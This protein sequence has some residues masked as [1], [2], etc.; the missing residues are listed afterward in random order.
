MILFAF[1]ALL[2]AA[3]WLI[4]RLGLRLAQFDRQIAAEGVDGEARVTDHHTLKAARGSA[5]SY[6]ITFQYPAGGAGGQ[7]QQFTE[8]AEISG[9]E[10]ERINPG[11]KISIRYLPTAPKEVIL[12]GGGRDRT[13]Q[14]FL[15]LGITLGAAG[16][17]LIV[18]G[19]VAWL[20]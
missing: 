1:G 17:V 18:I 5:Q 3:G 9:A 20:R 16:A 11:D 4:L 15:T 8:D 6:Y 10:Y 7:P 13:A 12:T 2:A 14:T 19:A